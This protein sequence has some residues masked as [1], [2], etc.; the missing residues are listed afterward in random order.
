MEVRRDES[1]AVLVLAAGCLV[2]LLGL[3]ALA[4]DI[5]V[6]H[7]QQRQIQNAADAAALGAAQDLVPSPTM[8]ESTA[9]TDAQNLAG[10]NLPKDT[11]NWAGCVDTEHLAVLAPSTQ[12]I[13]FASDG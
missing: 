9:V 12:C 3:S 7:T 11:L 5:G 1:G 2:V 8:K 6:G 4:I 13:S 10:E